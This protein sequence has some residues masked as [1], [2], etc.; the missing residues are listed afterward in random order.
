MNERSVYL[1]HAATTPT[2][3]RVLEAMLPYFTGEYGNPSSL[4]RHAAGARQALDDARR[5]VAEV[6]GA[7]PTEVIFSGCGTE[8]DNLAIRG[9]AMARRHEG[10]HIITTPIEHAAVLHTCEQLESAYGYRVTYLPVDATGMVDPD[11]VGRAI[12]SGTVL[13]SI[14]YANNEV[15]T[16]E[17]IAEISRITRAR[18]V[19]LH[20]DAVQA[21]GSLDLDVERLGVDL[22]SISGHKFYAPKGVGALYVRRGTP[23]LPAQTGGGQERGLRAGTENVPYIVGMARALEIASAER[24]AEAIRLGA[25]RDRLLAG[26]LATIPDAQVTGHPTQ[27]LPN[28]ASLAFTGLEGEALLLRLDMEGVQ[29]STGSACAAQEEG[30]S[31]VL[32]ALG[33]DQVAARGS[34]RLTLGR[35]TNDDDID[36]VLR[37]LP[38]IVETLRAMSP[39]YAS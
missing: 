23:L 16:I 8:S 2:D 35:A 25:L 10:N 6:L 1:D 27:R 4:Y 3:P 20:T 30:P 32:T 29:A 12:T 21:A 36:H 17:P 13:V 19:P 26:L 28:S 9:V 11:D 39:L 15:G 18:G 24:E 5:T 37:V 31:H 7:R 22:L 38:P 33:L 14:M 34:L